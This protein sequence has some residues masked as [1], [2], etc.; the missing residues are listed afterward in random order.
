MSEHDI[1]FGYNEYD[2][3]NDAVADVGQKIK[4]KQVPKHEPLR[5]YAVILHDSPVH[6]DEYVIEMLPKICGMTVEQAISLAL[7]LLT[8]AKQV[9]VF[10]GHLEVCELKREQ[11]ENYGGDPLAA[12]MNIKSEVSMTASIVPLDYKFSSCTLHAVSTACWRFKHIPN[13]IFSHKI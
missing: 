11:I 2:R 8:G 13:A 12:E 7:A 4:V 5:Q 3:N 9:Q 10:A 1:P 6:T